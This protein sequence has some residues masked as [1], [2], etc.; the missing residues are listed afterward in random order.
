[1]LR[2]YRGAQAAAFDYGLEDG[3]WHVE[4]EWRYEQ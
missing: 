3:V 2:R 4:K 1:V